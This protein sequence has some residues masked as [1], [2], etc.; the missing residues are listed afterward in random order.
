MRCECGDSQVSLAERIEWSQLNKTF[1]HLPNA[2]PVVM[3]TT[4]GCRPSRRHKKL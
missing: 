2:H 1:F 4:S 3:G